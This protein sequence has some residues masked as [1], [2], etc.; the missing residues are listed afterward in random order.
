[1]KV[2]LNSIKGFSRAMYGMA[3]IALTFIIALTVCDVILRYFRRPI[4]GTFELVAFTGAIVIGFAIP[5][6]SW[7]RG[8]I[9][10][11]FFILKLP[12]KIRDAFNV[13]TRLMGIG[14]FFLAGWNLIKVGMD[15]KKSGEVSL[16]LQLPFYPVAYGIGIACFVQCLVLVCDIM[17]IFGGEYE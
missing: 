17:K 11:D 4:T 8:H 15:L 7:V 13:T 10:V 1:M 14:L 5:L 9:F 2:F 16:T 3:G 12:K 6:T